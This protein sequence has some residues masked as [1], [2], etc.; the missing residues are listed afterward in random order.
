LSQ[1]RQTQNVS[2]F[3]EL[4]TAHATCKHRRCVI[5]TLR[6]GAQL[7]ACPPCGVR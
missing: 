2:K 3:H 4:D 6:L 1:T 5:C 7:E